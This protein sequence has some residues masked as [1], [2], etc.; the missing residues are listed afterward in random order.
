[1]FRKSWIGLN[2]SITSRKSGN[3]KGTTESPRFKRLQGRFTELLLLFVALNQAARLRLIRRL[4]ALKGEEVNRFWD[5]LFGTNGLFKD[6]PSALASGYMLPL[7]AE[8]VPERVSLLIEDGLKSICLEEHSSITKRGELVRTLE[9]LLFRKKTSATALRCLVMLAETN[10]VTSILCECF[11]PL[12]PQLPLPLQDRL[13]VLNEIL[14]PKNS[15]E[16]RLIGVE[17]IKSALKR[18][19]GISL[20]DSMGREPL[21]SQPRMTYG[22]VWSYIEAMVNLLMKLAQSEE[23]TLAESAKDALP[24]ALTEGAIQAR[25]EVAVAHFQTVVDWVLTD[26]VTIS[27]SDLTGALRRVDEQ[28]KKDYNLP[29]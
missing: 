17:A 29:P 18:M 10:N 16:L 20:R 1:M 12:H 13:N 7:V 14:S 22:D 28:E 2:N 24:R 8:A 25:P 5:E 11:R 26:K 9:Q 4:R 23:P 3:D 15:V 6:L 27:V 19:E 21:D